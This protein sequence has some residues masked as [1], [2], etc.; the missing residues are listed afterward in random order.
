MRV[1]KDATTS[2]SEPTDSAIKTPSSTVVSRGQADISTASP[3]SNDAKSGLSVPKIDAATL[4]KEAI[5]LGLNT[6]APWKISIAALIKQGIKLGYRPE[7][8]FPVLLEQGETLVLGQA[9]KEELVTDPATL[10]IQ[11]RSLI[12]GQKE[13][14]EFTNDPRDLLIQGRSLVLRLKTC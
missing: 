7:V 8:G 2:S 13:R 6:N 9:G 11:G 1:G 14:E 10:L 3:S 5:E 12:P 4:L